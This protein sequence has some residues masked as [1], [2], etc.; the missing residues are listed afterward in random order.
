MSAEKLREV[1]KNNEYVNDQE[2]PATFY[3]HRPREVARNHQPMIRF[4]DFPNEKALM[5]ISCMDPRANPNEFWNFGYGSPS[6]PGVLRNAGGRVTEDVLRSIRALSGIMSFGQ[7]TVGAVAVVHHK[8]CGL[9]NFSNEQVAE[10]LKKQAG[11][12]GERAKEVDK[13]DFLSWKQ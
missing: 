10:N 5:V 4:S 12:D 9:R 7:N 13:M 3:L 6:M 2:L 1:A 8:D 11:L